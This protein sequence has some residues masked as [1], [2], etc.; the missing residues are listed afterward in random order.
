MTALAGCE[1]EKIDWGVSNEGQLDCKSLSVDY[2]NSGNQTRAGVN[3]DDF[4]V[5]I[6]NTTTGNIAKSYTYGEMP[7][8]VAL[9]AGSYRA[10]ASYGDNPV[11]EWEAPYYLGNTE[12]DIEAGKITDDIAPIECELSN[13]RVRVN[14][15]DMGTGLLGNDVQVEVKAGK[16]GSKIF[17]KTNSDKSCYFKYDE[18]SGTITAKLSGTIDGEYR[19]LEPRI[20]T[21]AAPGNSYQITFTVNT[22]DNM[23]PGGVDVG[24]ITVE[25]TITIRNENMVVDLTNPD[26]GVITDD[27]RPEEGK[28]D[29]PKPD[30]PKPDDPTPPEPE[31]KGP[32]IEAQAPLILNK[33]CNVETLIVGYDADGTPQY[34]VKF[35]VTSETGI[36]EFKINIDSTTLTPDELENVEL[37]DNLDLINPGEFEGALNGL[38]FPTG[39][40]VKGKTECVFDIS[41]FV[42]LLNMLG[43]G[44][45]KFNLTV[46]D[47]N[48]SSKATVYLIN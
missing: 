34:S 22:P 46:S 33:G 15:D 27:M 41:Q 1:K 32:Q 12:F 13:I 25:T 2:I 37:T 26:A 44:E 39:D 10:E 14:T 17:D 31:K 30:D 8:I 3:I 24:G 47:A 35:K 5:N 48:G 4:K 43:S 42:P 7:D 23:E 40:N 9:P 11:A 45:H 28:T 18:G 19:T 20:Y 38:G 6:V 36:S 29:D 16:N 21:D